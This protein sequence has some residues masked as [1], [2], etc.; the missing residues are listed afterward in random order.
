MTV[1]VASLLFVPA[2]AGATRTSV[3]PRAER[4][5]TAI[6]GESPTPANPVAPL[7]RAG[8]SVIG[9]METPVATVPWQVAL[10]SN[11]GGSVKDRQFCGGTLVAPTIVITAAHCVLDNGQQTPPGTYQVVS[12]RSHLNATSQGTS[13]AVVDSVIWVDELDRPLFEDARQEWDVAVLELASPAAGEPILIAGPAERALWA[14][15]RLGRVSGWGVTRSA[16]YGTNQLMS[17]EVALLPDLS[18]RR[19]YRKFGGFRPATQLCA[20]RALGGH[21]TCQGDSGGPLVAYGADGT[22]RL[23]GITSYGRGCAGKYSPGVYA[24][25]AAD[26][27]RS[28]VADLLETS[29]GIDAVGDGALP[30]AQLSG[31]AARENAWLYLEPDCFEWG[32]CLAYDVKWCRWT[33]SGHRCLVTENAYRRRDGRFHC[34]QQVFVGI[35]GDSIMRQGVTKWQ[36]RR[37]WL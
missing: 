19:A 4:Y 10:V 37:G 17:T 5:S 29:Q 27:V 15:G 14:T 2:Q 32:P 36:C 13:T 20:G 18:C 26:P 9:G 25:V 24:R 1:L 6:G 21:D 28:A 34:S 8:I 22:P 33:G 30:P 3:E 7:P 35:S 11:G 16:P 12:G 31:L 23:V